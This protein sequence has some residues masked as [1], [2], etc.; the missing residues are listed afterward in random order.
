MQWRVSGFILLS[1][2]RIS[3]TEVNDFFLERSFKSPDGCHSSLSQSA[4]D[5]D[6]DDEEFE[7]CFMTL[8]EKPRLLSRKYLTSQ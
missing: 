8:E 2:V 3:T 4:K 6:E 7:N 1:V 5:E